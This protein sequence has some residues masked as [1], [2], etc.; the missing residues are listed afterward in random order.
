MPSCQ[1]PASSLQP[2]RLEVETFIK[3]YLLLFTKDCERSHSNFLIKSSFL[4]KQ[5]FLINIINYVNIIF[6]SSVLYSSNAKFYLL[7]P[8]IFI[9]K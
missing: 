8:I 1:L 7:I 9:M 3:D 6:F 2:W 4:F 5:L